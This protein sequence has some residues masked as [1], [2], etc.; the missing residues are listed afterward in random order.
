MTP[1]QQKPQIIDKK[2]AI[3]LIFKDI[4]CSKNSSKYNSPFLQNILMA[5]EVFHRPREVNQKIQ[6]NLILRG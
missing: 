6:R 4:L 1:K 2:D 5:L 3:S